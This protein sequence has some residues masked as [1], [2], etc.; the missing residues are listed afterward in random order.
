MSRNSKTFDISE[1][2][3]HTKNVAIQGQFE[4][5]LLKTLVHKTDES[6]MSRHCLVVG[7]QA[8]SDG[9][10]SEERYIVIENSVLNRHTSKKNVKVNYVKK[11]II[12]R[13]FKET[14]AR[15]SNGI[16]RY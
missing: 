12:E 5:G 13:D 16:L 3:K 9:Y 11:T 15:P 1:I 2:N 4:F 8:I 10:S 14:S 6:Q 7:Y